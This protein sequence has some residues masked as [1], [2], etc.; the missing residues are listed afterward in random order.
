MARGE[1]VALATFVQRFDGIL[2]ELEN[3]NLEQFQSVQSNDHVVTWQVVVKTGVNLV[4]YI[5]FGTIPSIV[6][7]KQAHHWQK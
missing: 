3:E 5:D 1:L 2:L 7:V 6:Q 4:C